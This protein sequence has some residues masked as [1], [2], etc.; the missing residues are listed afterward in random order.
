MNQKNKIKK[1]K[2]QVAAIYNSECYVCKKKFGKRF[3]F[4]HLKYY[5]TEKTY[6]DFN[7]NNNKYQLYILPIIEKRPKDF[8][9]LCF[10]HHYTVEQLKRFKFKNLERLFDIVWRSK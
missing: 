8:V 10:K 7:N 5:T 4:H 6:K 3:S 2:R 1:Y 9:L